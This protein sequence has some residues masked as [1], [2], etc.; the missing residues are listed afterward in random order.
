MPV[1]AAPKAQ[2]KLSYKHKFALETLPGKIEDATKKSAMLEAKL[3]DPALFAKN[4]ALF[5]KTAAELEA[6]KAS[7]AAMEDEWL[8]LEMLRAE[9]EGS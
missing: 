2:S 9:L 3:A 5:N 8:E 1:D 4:A 6:L 7:I